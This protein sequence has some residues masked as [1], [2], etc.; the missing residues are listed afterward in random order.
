MTKSAAPFLA[1]AL[2]PWPAALLTLNTRI[3]HS[4]PMALNFLLAAAIARIFGT[5]PAMVSVVSTALIFNWYCTSPAG[6]WSLGAP[7]LLQSA[8]ILAVG[9]LIVFLMQKHSK[10][11]LKLR[12][13]NAALQEQT[14]ALTQA[15]QGSRSAA[16]VYDAS[17]QKRTWHPG[18]AELFGLPLAEM[19]EIGLP[20]QLI[21]D[22]DRRKLAAAIAATER[23]GEPFH[24]EFRICRPNGEIRW[25]E[26]SGRPEAAN[27]A[28]WRGVTMDVTSR[29]TAELA[30]LRSEKL[31][32]TARLATSVSHEI[33]NPLEAITN[34]LYLA[35]QSAT[36]AK[37][38]SYLDT[39]EKEV[40]RIAQVTIQTL[41]FH[42]QKS[43]PTRTDIV[44]MIAELLRFYE[45]RL[46]RS[47]V[48][49]N[50]EPHAVP[51]LVCHSTEMRQ[52]LAN[53]IANALDSMPN[54][55]DLKVRVRQG[56]DWRS[57]EQGLRITIADTGS[58]I[59]EES[60]RQI[61]EPFFTTKDNTSTGL[62][63][64]LTAGI[65]DGH[66]GSIHVRSRN[67]DGRS[68]TAF[69]MILPIQAANAPPPPATMP[70]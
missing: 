63:L 69:S 22:A 52:A 45:F 49:V 7:Q 19:N 40:A 64:W 9:A 25:L 61:Y 48:T 32:A 43:T 37:T 33:N 59:S 41:Q 3:L 51:P 56:I 66:K 31:A 38:Q 60:R 57:G 44:A 68:G 24:A 18:G 65:V 20:T 35:K 28:I 55:G 16:W 23:T 8:A 30:L 1:G 4:T 11:E 62:G 27:P 42:T 5:A 36:D 58:G 17:T 15:Q 14:D 10:V 13:A 12:R 6:H 34:L 54:G 26:S 46:S 39:A 2:L 50:F 70:N 29:K 47:G 67:T 53:L 21:V